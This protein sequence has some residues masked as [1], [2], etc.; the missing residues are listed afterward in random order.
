MEHR[1]KSDLKAFRKHIC[2]CWKQ[3]NRVHHAPLDMRSSVLILQAMLY[4]LL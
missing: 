4:H 1:C 3:T 2:S